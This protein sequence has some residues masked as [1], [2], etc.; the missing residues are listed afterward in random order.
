VSTYSLAHPASSYGELIRRKFP[1][2]LIDSWSAHNLSR[3]QLR[4]WLE[5]A[6]RSAM[7]IRPPQLAHSASL[8]GRSALRVL[9]CAPVSLAGNL[10]EEL[11]TG[12]GRGR[13]TSPGKSLAI[14]LTTSPW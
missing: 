14:W 6:P 3:C 5:R 1:T 10:F 11:L 13:V 2:P 7:F 4:L 8:I 9:S 12:L